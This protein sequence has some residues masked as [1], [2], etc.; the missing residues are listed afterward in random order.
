M[1]G[2]PP[3]EGEIPCKC[4]SIAHRKVLA[5]P[6]ILGV[7]NLFFLNYHIYYRLLAFFPEMCG[8]VSNRSVIFFYIRN[9]Q[10]V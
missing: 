8:G 7:Y 1:A 3:V 4:A 2:V 9:Y 10:N 5:C 6:E